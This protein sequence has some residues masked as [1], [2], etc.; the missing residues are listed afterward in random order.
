MDDITKAATA[1]AVYRYM[2]ARARF[3]KGKLPEIVPGVPVTPA[4]L[5]HELERGLR[6]LAGGVLVY[7]Q[8][9]PPVV[10]DDEDP[11]F[12]D[13]INGR[14]HASEIDADDLEKLRRYVLR[15]GDPPPYKPE[16]EEP[17][18]KGA[19]PAETATWI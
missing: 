2:V 16:P 5:E 4:S 8:A 14:D 10:A 12:L 19:D 7:P 15:G 3:R 18:S 17:S 11:G 13:A 1:A 9:S 6:L